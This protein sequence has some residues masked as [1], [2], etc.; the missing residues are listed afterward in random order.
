M[1]PLRLHNTVSMQVEEFAP[2]EPGHVRMYTCG[3]TVHDYSHVGNFRTVLFQDLLRRVLESE[4][5]RVTQVMNITDV[6]DRI[7]RKA[8][9]RSQPIDEYTAPFIDAYHEDLRTLRVEPAAQYPRATR[10]IP[11]KQCWSCSP[12]KT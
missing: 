3:P 11:E 9:E 1:T 2:I 5:Y 12:S 10:H 8:A 7:I 6:E 4:G